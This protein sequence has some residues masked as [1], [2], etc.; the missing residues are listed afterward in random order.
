MDPPY[1]VSVN[2]LPY[3]VVTADSFSSLELK[4]NAFK[5]GLQ[6]E[7]TAYFYFQDDPFLQNR[8]GDCV[9]NNLTGM[10]LMTRQEFAIAYSHLQAGYKELIQKAGYSAKMME[11]CG[12]WVKELAERFCYMNE[13]TAH[14]WFSPDENLPTAIRLPRDPHDNGSYMV[15]LDTLKVVKNHDKLQRSH[16]D[17]P[18][19]NNEFDSVMQKLA[20]VLPRTQQKYQMTSDQVEYIETR[21]QALP[22]SLEPQ[23]SRLYINGDEVIVCEVACRYFSLNR[24]FFVE[25]RDHV[26]TKMDD[27]GFERFCALL[28]NARQT[29]G[30]YHYFL[31]GDLKM[32][33]TESKAKGRIVPLPHS[34]KASSVARIEIV[35][36]DKIP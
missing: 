16:V 19:T 36:S 14:V 35:K 5:I 25:A 33:Y 26:W 22:A 29:N 15:L 24:G 12:L 34:L 6:D 10:A 27:A 18:V 20:D 21:I 8:R 23:R 28:A 9:I 32:R 17:I 31:Q 4:P 3:L 7:R 1:V 2:L 13:E 30:D 11:A